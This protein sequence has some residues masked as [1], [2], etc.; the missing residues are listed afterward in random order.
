M[1]ETQDGAPG[2][3][4]DAATEPE[5][6]SAPRAGDLLAALG[7]LTPAPVRLREPGSEEFGRGTVFFPL[8]GLLMGVA[9]AGLHRLLADRLPLWLTACF[10]VTAWEALGRGRTLAACRYRDAEGWLE[11]A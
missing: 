2:R 11:N 5:R 7:W 6:S 9:L 1:Q 8:V 3:H 10:V 4:P